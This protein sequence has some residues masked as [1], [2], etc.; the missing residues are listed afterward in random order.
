MEAVLMWMAVVLASLSGVLKEI[1]LDGVDVGAA[2]RKLPA[3]DPK[4]EPKPGKRSGGVPGWGEG[5][6]VREAEFSDPGES[7]SAAK[8]AAKSESVEVSVLLW[9]VVG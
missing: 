7:A 4:P 9:K 6:C 2:F 5:D 1:G 3:S 8:Q